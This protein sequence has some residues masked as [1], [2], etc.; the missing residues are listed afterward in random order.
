ME[1]VTPK[2][3]VI[4]EWWS[5]NSL[6]AMLPIFLSLRIKS[7]MSIGPSHIGVAASPTQRSRSL[8]IRPLP[9]ICFSPA[10]P[11]PSLSYV[12]NKLH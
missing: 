9:F 2:L 7:W 1:R 10:R 11:R 6:A 3:R 12:T 5:Y 8:N 4:L